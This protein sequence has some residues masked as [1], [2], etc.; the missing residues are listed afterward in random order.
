MKIESEVRNER[1]RLHPGY[2]TLS[3]DE[4]ANDYSTLHQHE[5]VISSALRPPAVKHF[6]CLKTVTQVFERSEVANF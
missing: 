5:I 2:L 6:P 3:S 4:R 1:A